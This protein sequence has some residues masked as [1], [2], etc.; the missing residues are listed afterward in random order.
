M[1]LAGMSTMMPAQLGLESVQRK[2]HGVRA[3]PQI[4]DAVQAAAVGDLAPGF[5][6]QHRTRDFDGHTREHRAR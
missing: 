2:R 4:D 1:M 3:R 6:D 5:L